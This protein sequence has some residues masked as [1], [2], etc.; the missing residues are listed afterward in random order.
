MI[1]QDWAFHFF[2]NIDK[3]SSEK[4][5]QYLQSAPIIQCFVEP[6]FRTIAASKLFGC[7]PAI[8]EHLFCLFLC[9]K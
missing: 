7:V 6:S 9:V 1:V 4:C 3:F 8:F 5:V 2:F